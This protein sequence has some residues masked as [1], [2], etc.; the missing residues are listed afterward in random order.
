MNAGSETTFYI[1]AVYYGSVQVRAVRHTLA[2]C[3][4][5]DTVGLTGAVYLSRLFFG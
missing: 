1:L 2:A 3:L 5:A 4:V